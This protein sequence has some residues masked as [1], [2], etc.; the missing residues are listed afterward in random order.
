MNIKFEQNGR[1]LACG[2]AEQI[3]AADNVIVIDDK[4]IADDF[5]RTFAL[6]KYR[7]DPQK[8]KLVEKKDFKMPERSKLP[9]DI[10]QRSAIQ[11]RKSDG[12]EK[13]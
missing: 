13:K 1:I 2:I 12:R 4:D 3:P 9:D 7:V 11:K 10:A 8:K 6:G 5:L